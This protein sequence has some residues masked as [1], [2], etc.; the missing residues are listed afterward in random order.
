MDKRPDYKIIEKEIL[1][2]WNKIKKFLDLILTK[3]RDI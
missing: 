2:L 3:I 1:N